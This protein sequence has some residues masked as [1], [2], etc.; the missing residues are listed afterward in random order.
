M[1]CNSITGKLDTIKCHVFTYKPDII[2]ITETKLDDRIDDNEIFGNEYTVWRKDRDFRGGG[3]LVAI[4]NRSCIKV[5]SCLFGPGE[6][7]TLSIQMHHKLCFNLVTMYRPPTYSEHNLDSFQ[8]LLEEVKSTNV[9]MLGDYNLPDINWNA[10]GCHGG[11]KPNTLN[12]GF[13]DRALEMIHSA[14][15]CQL[16]KE[17]T[18]NRGNTLD[19]VMINKALLNDI[20]VDC[21][22]LPYI[23]DH[24]MILVNI[25]TQLTSKF[26][27]TEEKKYL[28]YNQADYTQI[29]EKF[30]NL[31][32]K[33]DDHLSMEDMWQEFKK[34]CNEATDNIPGKLHKPKGHPWIKRDLVKLIRKSRRLYA[35]F[36][37][38]PSIE[39][40][41]AVEHINNEIKKQTK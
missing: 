30:N 19:L 14:D 7:V 3:V 15:L 38:F 23:S 24:N 40:N 13:H 5:I 6:S 32:N 34:T 35:T 8:E 18:H 25:T 16:I 36:K 9:I 33:L 10:D 41:D 28:N 26:L 12:R 11:V 39:T 21:S 4:D 31:K 17:S 20:N 37:R 27:K 29:D 22:V 2:S 1:N